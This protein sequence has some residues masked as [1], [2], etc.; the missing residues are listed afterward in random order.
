VSIALPP[1][2]TVGINAGIERIL[3]A[4]TVHAPDSVPS[5]A[6]PRVT[7][8][9]LTLD[10]RRLRCFRVLDESDLTVSVVFDADAAG[11]LEAATETIAAYLTAHVL[12]CPE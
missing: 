7:C 9:G 2:G 1:P 3:L 11:S 4:P 12:N 5:A 6:A 8:S 10:G